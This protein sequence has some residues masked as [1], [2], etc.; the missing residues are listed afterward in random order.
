MRDFK[1]NNIKTVKV[2]L[3]DMNIKMFCIYVIN[4]KIVM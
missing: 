2:N 4:K 1:I 3:I